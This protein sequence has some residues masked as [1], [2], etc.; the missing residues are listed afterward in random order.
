MENLKQYIIEIDNDKIVDYKAIDWI[1]T[2][3]E[4]VNKKT[5]IASNN[6]TIKVSYYDKDLK[7]IYSDTFKFVDGYLSK[8]KL[9]ADTDEINDLFENAKNDIYDEIIENHKCKIEF[10]ENKIK[11]L[12]NEIKILNHYKNN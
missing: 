3:N 5:S 12:N 1:Y 9:V 4:F 7:K 8:H 6:L 10:L 11:C 2:F